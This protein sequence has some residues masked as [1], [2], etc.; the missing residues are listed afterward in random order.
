MLGSARAS[1]D[2]LQL[3]RTEEKFRES[4]EKNS[5]EIDLEVSSRE[6]LRPAASFRSRSRP[7]RRYLPTSLREVK[8]HGSA[9][10][11]RKKNGPVKINSESEN[12]TARSRREIRSLF[13]PFLLFLLPYSAPKSPC[14][15]SVCSLSTSQ[16][17]LDFQC[18][19][20]RPT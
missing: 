12:A 6:K 4:L 15:T 10:R 19:R 5:K 3:E 20:S 14:R 18:T 9:P 16:A 1:M 7:L 8:D 17:Y 13:P 11:L 2:V